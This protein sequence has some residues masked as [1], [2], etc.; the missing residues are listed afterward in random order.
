VTAPQLVPI[1]LGRLDLVDVLGLGG[2]LSLRE[3]ATLAVPLVSELW[4]DSEWFK[5]D[6][7]LW[8]GLIFWLLVDGWHE[9]LV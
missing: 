2:L 1:G 9:P 4:V 7:I 8:L 5:C 6:E 3:L